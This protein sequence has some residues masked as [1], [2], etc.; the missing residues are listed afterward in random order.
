MKIKDLNLELYGLTEEKLI[1]AS[2]FLNDPK[3]FFDLDNGMTC[4]YT[5]GDGG[6]ALIS[7]YSGMFEERGFSI[8]LIECE[9]CEF[10]WDYFRQI[11]EEFELNWEEAS[12]DL[13]NCEEE[14]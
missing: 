10:D 11:E 12:L 3:A 2:N 13:D 8:R 6:L 5:D 1:K 14:E 4:I 9:W 7:G